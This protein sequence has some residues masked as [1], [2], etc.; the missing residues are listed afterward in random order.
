MQVLQALSNIRNLVDPE[1]LLKATLQ[2]AE[3]QE[4][5]HR[6][7]KARAGEAAEAEQEPISARFTYKSGPSRTR[8]GQ[9]LSFFATSGSMRVVE[10]YLHRDKFFFQSC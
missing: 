4:A 9:Y 3:P 1:L 5:E 10:T 8:S 2:E 7:G 6:E